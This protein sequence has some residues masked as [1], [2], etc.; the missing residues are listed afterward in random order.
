[1]D[2]QKTIMAT[3][4]D[5]G[6]RIV[7]LWTVKAWAAVETADRTNLCCRVFYDADNQQTGFD[8]HHIVGH[9]Q[10][11]LRFSDPRPEG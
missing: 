9:S 2:A 3:C 10:K 1:M 6:V 8:Y 4:A 5:C 7:Y 11:R